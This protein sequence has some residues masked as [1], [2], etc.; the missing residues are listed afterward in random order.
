MPK[1]QLATVFTMMKDV[2]ITISGDEL[3]MK[4]FSM[5]SMADIVV[6]VRNRD[7]RRFQ[8]GLVGWPGS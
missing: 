4:V 1:V 6:R 3:P 5:S 7:T 2:M 8:H